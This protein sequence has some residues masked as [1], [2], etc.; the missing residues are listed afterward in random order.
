VFLVN[1]TLLTISATVTTYT[2]APGQSEPRS[3][4]GTYSVEPG[5]SWELGCDASA[6]GGHVRYVLNGWK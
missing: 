1:N 4:T 5:G 3:S 6:G 2:E